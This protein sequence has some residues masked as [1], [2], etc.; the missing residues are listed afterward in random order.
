MVTSVQP[1]VGLLV[2]LP[3]GAVGMV[4]ITD[5]A[6]SYRPNPL[7]MF[8]KDQLVRLVDDEIVL[9]LVQE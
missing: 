9:L 3:F 4:S 7:E 6:D 2:K 1:Q 8:S 5:I